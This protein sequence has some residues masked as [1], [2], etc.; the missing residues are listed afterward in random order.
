MIDL[1]THS[2]RVD[3]QSADASGKTMFFQVICKLIV[4][5]LVFFLPIVGTSAQNLQDEALFKRGIARFQQEKFVSARLDFSEII[6]HYPHSGRVQEAYVM[7]AKT[8]FR[9]GDYASAEDTVAQLRSNYPQSTYIEWSEYLLAACRFSENDFETAVTMLAS[10]AGKTDDN[11]LKNHIFGA[12]RYSILPL[13]DNGMVFRI[14]ESHGLKRSDV[15]D[16][17]IPVD[18]PSDEMIDDVRQHVWTRGSTI[19]IG[20]VAPLSGYSASEGNEL[21]RGVMSAISGHAEINGKSVEILVEDTESD[22]II[23]AL[24]TRKLIDEGVMAVIGPVYGEAS[25]TAALESNSRGIP[26]LAPTA[27]DLGLPLLGEYVYQLNQ[28]PV[29]QATELAMFASESLGFD[30]AAIIASDDWWGR[31][32]TDTFTS[33]FENRGGVII[34]TESFEPS[35][36]RYNYNDILMRIRAAAPESDAAADS[37]IVFESGNAFADTVIVIPDPKTTLQR[38]KPVTSLDCILVSAMA[39][40]AINIVRQIRD[41]HINAVLLG[42]SGWS[43]ESIA[44]DLGPVV[45]G[46]YLVST[47]M[48]VS[49]S[50]GSQ[51]F[52]DDFNR[53]LSELPNYYARKGYDACAL[54]IHCL[55][56]GADNPVSIKRTLGTIMDF[57][58]LSSRYTLDPVKRSNTAVD[59]IQIQNGYFVKIHRIGM[60]DDDAE[61]ETITRTPSANN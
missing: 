48:D 32:V 37:M 59:F 11:N 13:A 9:L 8:F 61:A 3:K 28:T 16:A 33:V 31:A 49:D 39:D 22:P 19:K 52:T 18:I 17:K 40:D 1:K 56:Q 42:D 27:S 26:F 21:M 15:E 44:G 12:L 60:I 30:N 47:T 10:L 14:L 6:N 41:Y 55:A 54:L 45:D 25:I 36:N 34:R 23:A 4:Y 43:D 53:R 57:K 5:S 50:F 38:L 20:L 24:K 7:L 2:F 51:Y 29:V 46:A 58:G 35:A